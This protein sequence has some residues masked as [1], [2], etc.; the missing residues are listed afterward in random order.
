MSRGP[1]LDPE[2][3]G[4]GV[5]HLPDPET[6]PYVWLG[7]GQYISMPCSMS[8]IGKQ[9]KFCS[10]YLKEI[11]KINYIILFSFV[12]HHLGNITLA[13]YVICFKFLRLLKTSTN[14]PLVPS[15]AKVLN[16]AVRRSRVLPSRCLSG[17]MMK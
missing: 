12:C 17:H 10:E 13:M 15:S 3:K 1:V 5:R 9:I 11:Y 8:V 16:K 6:F 14:L 2:T 7:V 4:L